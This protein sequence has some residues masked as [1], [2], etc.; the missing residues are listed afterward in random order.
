MNMKVNLEAKLFKK[1]D[2]L[3][4]SRDEMY[5]ALRDLC[6][7]LAKGQSRAKKEAL[8]TL[9]AEAL[10][11]AHQAVEMLSS[12]EPLPPGAVGQAKTSYNGEDMVGDDTPL[13]EL[14]Q[15]LISD[16]VYQDLEMRTAA[17]AQTEERERI[18]PPFPVAELRDGAVIGIP[19]DQA[20]TREWVFRDSGQQDRPFNEREQWVWN[21]FIAEFKSF[22]QNP[23]NSTA[24]RHAK[25]LAYELKTI[26][27]ILVNEEF[28]K[29]LEE[30]ARMVRDARRSHQVQSR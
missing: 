20:K 30:G 21:R 19:E 25:A 9:Y 13:S 14:E 26:Y 7:D 18:N 11:Q 3:A 12:T 1:E 10:V 4:L 23:A 22:A 5:A 16:E 27:R 8:V 24:R 28:L 2:F 29:K 17:V 15:P 6:P